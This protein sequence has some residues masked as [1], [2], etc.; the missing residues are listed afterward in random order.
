MSDKENNDTDLELSKSQKP[1]TDNF[2]N[3]SQRLKKGSSTHLKH[4]PTMEWRLDSDRI[5]K[6]FGNVVDYISVDELLSYISK[7]RTGQALLDCE[8]CK[9]IKIYY[10]PQVAASQYYSETNVITINPHRPKAEM[11]M[12][13]A[14]ELRRSWQFHNGVLLNPLMFEPDEA[15]LLNRAQQADAMMISIR[16]AWELKL[17]GEDLI[18]DYMVGSPVVDVLRT[19]EIHASNDFRSLNNGEAA[20]AAYD[21]WF[22][23]N[24]LKMHDKR[25]IHQM[26]LDDKLHISDKYQNH[27]GQLSN[28]L[29]AQLGDLPDGKN[30]LAL[31]GHKL[32]THEDYSAVE[33]RS[34]ANFLWFIK[35]ERSFQE[36]EQQMIQESVACSAEVVDFASKVQE[37]RQP[38][39]AGRS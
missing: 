5:A 25:I 34:N 35:F 39:L 36:K 30:Y 17:S 3:R 7:S 4:R 22:E 6:P 15:I 11:V 16:L 28:E 33:D 8:G 1:K 37:M 19:F 9:D 38:H 32:P 12:M 24:R 10:D 21:K 31:N 18:W 14:R 2:K 26:L 27:Q 29:L 13:L 20:R 23:D